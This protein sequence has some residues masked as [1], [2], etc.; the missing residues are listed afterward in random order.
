MIERARDIW[1][2]RPP[3]LLMIY[4]GGSDIA[5]KGAMFLVTVAAARTLDRADFGRFALATTLGWLASV[6]AD[7]GIQAHLARAVAQ[8]PAASAALLRRWMPVRVASGV[9]F[10]LFALLSLRLFGTEQRE[11]LPMA[12]LV[13][14]YAASGFSEC[15]YYF[16]RGLGRTDLESTF[17]LVQRSV[18]CGLAIGALWFNPTLTSLALAMLTPAV[19]TASAA[20]LF[21]WWLAGEPNASRAVRVE[22]AREATGDATVVRTTT[23]TLTQRAG[24]P[25]ASPPA[26]VSSLAPRETLSHELMSSVA[27]I[28]V[29]IL[30]SALYFRIDVFLLERWSGT[31]QVGLYNAVFRVIDALR[32]FPAAA[33]AVTLPSLCRA[34]D[35]RPLLRVAVPLTSAAIAVALVLWFAATP[36]VT[37]LYGKSFSSAVA[38]FRT[39]LLSLPLMTLNYALTQQLIGWHGQQSFALLCAFA[40]A[41]N[42]SLNAVLIPVSGMDGAAWSTLWTETFL[43]IG[44]AIALIRA[45]PT[46]Q[47]THASVESSRAELGL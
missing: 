25:G 40:L 43:T 39:L 15:M 18:M 14:V 32:L 2:R 27:P 8:Q 33:L 23:S 22:V 31:S 42:V 28:G 12:L 34:R 6:A 7:M 9:V 29:G 44:C 5:A 11:W 17:T 10:L 4:R 26:A 41:V 13:T 1:R 16:F 19:V 46:S 20:L 35:A 30:L 3:G 47:V 45:I 24:S 38:P 37:T 21:A 36:V